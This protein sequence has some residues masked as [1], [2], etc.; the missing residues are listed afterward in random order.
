MGSSSPSRDQTQ[1]PFRESIESLPLDH[2]RSPW[3]CPFRITHTQTHTNNTGKSWTTVLFLPNS[4]LFSCHMNRNYHSTVLA[5]RGFELPVTLKVITG[6][7]PAV[8]WLG[9]RLLMQEMWVQ[10]LVRELRSHMPH[11]QNTKTQNWSNIV[12]NSIKTLKNGPHF[13]KNTFF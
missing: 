5:G 9:L 6:T 3:P 2:Q 1:T 4:P 8:R 10:S 13:F 11:G 12:T 7:S